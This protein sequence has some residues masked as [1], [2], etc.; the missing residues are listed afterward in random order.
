MCGYQLS[1][2]TLYTFLSLTHIEGKKEIDTTSI[3]E[4]GKLK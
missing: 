1:L 3:G 2:F 4:V